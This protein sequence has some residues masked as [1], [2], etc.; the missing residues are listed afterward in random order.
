MAPAVSGEYPALMAACVALRSMR[1]SSQKRF[2]FLVKRLQASFQKIIARQC[3]HNRLL[4]SCVL[5]PVPPA[6]RACK[7]PALPL[8]AGAGHD[9]APGI[10]R[11]LLYISLHTGVR[12][13]RMGAAQYATDANRSHAPCPTHRGR[14]STWCAQVVPYAGLAPALA[15]FRLRTVG[16]GCTAYRAGISAGWWRPYTG[17]RKA[18]GPCPWES[19][20]HQIRRRLSCVL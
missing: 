16:G 20:T 6:G 5:I 10:C 3:K 15:P 8:A 19:I 2:C 17:R 4:V 9:K 1:Y 13:S 14:C 11:W 12:L 18:L 7:T